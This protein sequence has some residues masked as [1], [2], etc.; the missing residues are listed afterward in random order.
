VARQLAGA[1]VSLATL[2]A[3]G[4]A[5]GQGSAGDDDASAV[6]AAPALS[7]VTPLPD[8]RAWDGLVTARVGDDAVRPVADDPEPQ[9][10]IRVTDAQGTRVTVTDTSRILAL[11]VYG[12]YA[13]TVFELGLGSHVVG[14]DISTQFAEARELP[15][16]TTQGH[17]LDAE[18]ILD[19]DPSVVLVDTTLGPWSAV[20]QLRDSGIPVVVLPSTRT[21]E[22]APALAEK[23]AQALGVPPAG[24]ALARRIRAGTARVERQ[25]EAVAPHELGDRLRTVFLY[26]RGQSGI[27]YM[28]GEGSGADSLIDSLG[29]YDV[30]HEIGWDGMKPVTDEGLVAAQPELVLMMTD[31]LRSVGGVDGLLRRLP[32]LAQT[33]AGQHRR[34]VDM[35]D[36]EI[37]GFGPLTAQVL[38]ALAV[39]IYAPASIAGKPS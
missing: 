11:D 39:A 13:R 5:S 38:N 33:P 19:L 3:C 37:L 20:E 32:A 1:L 35:Q 21:I 36:S 17:E 22:G 14:R 2:V 8:P 34:I 15:L 31:G 28:F 24:R 12:T 18:R 7:S 29:L 4:A 9:L 25:V 27:Y 16:V 30:A 23:V 10:P 26:V 6:R